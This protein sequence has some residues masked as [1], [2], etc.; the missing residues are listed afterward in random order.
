MGNVHDEISKKVKEKVD[1][2]EVYKSMDL[3]RERIIEGLISDYSNKKKVDLTK[4]NSWTIKLNQF[5]TKH[6]M[7]TR[8]LVTMEMFE[9]FVNRK[10]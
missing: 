8:K 3:E 7:P 5:A 6:Q 10:D 9:A 4:L 2:I 1:S